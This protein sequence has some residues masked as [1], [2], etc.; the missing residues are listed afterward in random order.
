MPLPKSKT[1]GPPRGKPRVPPKLELCG[2]CRQFVQS[3]TNFC[4]WCGAEVQALAREYAEK[5][6]AARRTA[7]HIE[8]LLRELRR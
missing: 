4:P 7:L 1:A 6:E 8:R 5:L 2:G 3:E